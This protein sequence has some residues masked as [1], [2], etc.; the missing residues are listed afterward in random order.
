MANLFERLSSQINSDSF[1]KIPETKIEKPKEGFF[2]RVKSAI[3]TYIGEPIIGSILRTK[4]DI[5]EQGLLR[6]LGARVTRGS[7]PDPTELLTTREQII[8]EQPTLSPQE[9]TKLAVRR[10]QFKQS[11]NL[12]TGSLGE[13]ENIIKKPTAKVT[14]EVLERIAKTT[15][16]NVVKRIVKD[17]IPDIQEEELKN[18]AIK[19]AAQTDKKI[20]RNTIDDTLTSLVERGFVTSAKKALPEAERIAGQYI[21]RSTD[22]L[23][24]KAKNLIADDIALAERRVATETGED[25]V[26]IASELIKHYGDEAAKTTDA[27][28][29]NSLY[30][31]A[32]KI[33]NIIA[34]KLTESGRTIQAASILGRLTPEGQVRFASNQILKYNEKLPLAKRIPELTGEQ[35]KEI[36]QK[37]KSINELP[38]GVGKAMEFQKLQNYV[39]S[40][41][42]TPVFQKIIAVWKA[43]L[44]TGIKTSG[45]NIMSNLSHA[46][47]EV[48]KDIPATMVDKIISLFTGKRTVALTTKGLGAGIREGFEKGMRYLKTGFDE[49]NIGTK[50]DYNRV[51][52]GKGKIAKALQAYTDSVFRVIGAEDQPFYYASKIRSLYEQAKVMAI[53]AKLKGAEAQKFIDD[54]IQNPTD[55]MVKFASMDAETAVFQNPTALGKA[56]KKIQQIGGGAGEIIVPFGK[57]PSAVAMQILNYSPIGLVK[58]IVS[59]I[60]KGR[61]NQRAFSKGIG[62]GITGLGALFI[63]FELANKGMITFA[64]PTTEKEQK[65]WEL[66]GRKENSFY[67]QI[68]KKWRSLSILGPVGNLLMMGGL[69]KQEFDN[70]GTPTKAMINTLGGSAQAFSQQTFLTGVSN[71]IDAVTDPARSAEYV[72]GSTLA[73]TVP[74]IVSDI[75]R[76]TDTKERR[77]N[78]I[79]EKIQARIPGLRT[80]LEPQVTVL[81]EDKPIMGNP[82]EVIID[83]TRPSP[84]KNSPVISELRRLWDLGFKVSPTLL[85]DKKGYESLTPEENTKLWR[86]AGDITNEKLGKLIVNQQYSEMADDEKAKTIDKFVENAKVNAR[87][88]MAIELTTGLSGEELSSKLS[89]LKQSGLLTRD[90]YTKYQQLR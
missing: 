82:L 10:L 63:G 45:L 56:A 19:L 85:G 69:F 75:A 27:A 30:D 86:R 35:A 81:G 57:T 59:N 83:P 22:E 62:R 48:A 72:A 28:I 40:L 26:A 39:S 74:T 37:M 42:P 55:E 15:E 46:A 50:L 49:R 47:T 9:A 90:V 25:A 1:T 54:L 67:D 73:S 38:E 31:S 14:E 21:P 23:A 11:E 66:E 34:P 32:A 79:M 84:A 89:E 5:E 7:L 24:I 80:T 58:T 51:N 6:G 70:T 29:K 17:I 77:A 4:K 68:G 18:I 88:E 13:G 52:F 33:A 36:L 2:S 71:F 61:F 65:L 12:V 20:I 53:N 8:K 60:G 3:D 76:A 78:E 64:R 87:A 16:P 44:L 43:G 41:V